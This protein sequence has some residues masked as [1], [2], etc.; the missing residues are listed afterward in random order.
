MFIALC[1]YAT[2]TEAQKFVVVEAGAAGV[3]ETLLD[4]DSIVVL[5]VK[6][7]E[8]VRFRYRTVNSGLSGT[9]VSLDYTAVGSCDDFVIQIL[10][11]ESPGTAFKKEYFTERDG[12]SSVNVVTPTTSESLG[13]VLLAACTHARTTAIDRMSARPPG[14]IC[15]RAEDAIARLMCTARAET[16]LTIALLTERTS[17]VGQLCGQEKFLQQELLETSAQANALCGGSSTCIESQFRRMQNLITRDF[18]ELARWHAQPEPRSASKDRWCES[19]PELRLIADARRLETQ[20]REAFLVRAERF[21]SCATTAARR[22][23]DRRSDVEAIAN[24]AI[25]S[26]GTDYRSLSGSEPSEVTSSAES[27]R[28]QLRKD[29]VRS[30][31]ELR[32]SQKTRK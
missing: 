13:K 7:L 31:L 32:A 30:L 11:V 19:I 9:R 16:R 29:L 17:R 5:P 14:V 27:L 2:S 24:A 23:E 21:R 15:D 22:L 25:E 6:E 12:W 18:G 28:T 8:S 26:C 10:R 4:V 20:R 1:L 3:A